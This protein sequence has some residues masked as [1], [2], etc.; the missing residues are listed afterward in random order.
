MTGNWFGLGDVAA[1]QGIKFSLSYQHQFQQN[2]RGGVRTFNAHDFSGSY[3]A[4]ITLDFE[5][6]GLWESAGFYLKFKGTHGDGINDFVGARSSVNSDAEGDKAV[7]VKKWWYWDKLFDDKIEFR[8]GML[9]TNKDLYDVGLYAN[10]EDKD[11]LNRQSIR[12]STIPQTTGI[13]AHVRVSPVDW[14]YA[15]AAVLDIQYEKYRT[16]FDTAFHGEDWFVGLAEIG[17]TPEWETPKGPMPGSYRLG[18]SYDPRI[19]GVFLDDLDGRIEIPG[20]GG[21][22]GFYFGIDQMVFKENDDPKDDQGLGLFGRYGH[23]RSDATLMSDYWSAGASYKGLIPGRDKD[24]M[25]FATSQ[26]MV[27]HQYRREIN[28]LGDR[29]TVYEWYYRIQ[30]TPWLL[31]TPDL[32]YITQAG[33]RK[34]SGNALVGGVRLRFIF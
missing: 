5:R 14:F 12:N 13:G 20:M 9:E 3:D 15:Q 29:E 25:A 30:V 19:R 1:E 4:T 23:V 17:F 10:H 28:P 34:D 32:Q 33:A 26:S 7:F 27:S 8:L 21:H 24:I 6:M 2:L 18:A 11:F 31:V 22:V 16:G